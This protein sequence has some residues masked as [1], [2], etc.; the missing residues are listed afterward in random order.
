MMEESL[1]KEKQSMILKGTI[2]GGYYLC[3]S[4]STFVSPIYTFSWRE[5][6]LFTR[7]IKEKV[8]KSTLIIVFMK[9]K[10]PTFTGNKHLSVHFFLHGSRLLHLST[11]KV[12]AFS[13]GIGHQIGYFRADTIF[14]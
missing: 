8:G 12:L 11:E 5:T 9:E 6:Y 1:N 3:N 14:T 2:Q 7:Q 10:M 4:N 13:V